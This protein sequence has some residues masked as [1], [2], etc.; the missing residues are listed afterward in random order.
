MSRRRRKTLRHD[1]EGV[2]WSVVTEGGQCR[3]E[4]VFDDDP[5]PVVRSIARTERDA[6]VAEQ[7]ANGFV[8]QPAWEPTLAWVAEASDQEFTLEVLDAW[9]VSTQ[10]QWSRVQHAPSPVRTW[11][12]LDCLA[13]QCSRNGLAMYFMDCD[14][15]LVLHTEEAAREAGLETLATQFAAVHKGTKKTPGRVTLGSPKTAK[16]VEAFAMME[17]PARLLAW[18]RTHAASF[19]PVPTSD[20]V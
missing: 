5:E 6:L 2:T 19:L 11:L 13:A 8:L 18:A 9:I 12:V 14:P 3:I 1:A 15:E 20:T 4:I 16:A 17:L 7:L 10:L